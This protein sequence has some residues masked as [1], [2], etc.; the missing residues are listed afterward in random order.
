VI[1]QFA[2]VAS[3]LDPLADPWREPFMRLALAEVVLLGAIGGAL[4]CWI[5]LY[6]LAY[7]AESLAHGM[8]PGLAIA[9]LTAIPLALGGL[10]GGLVAAL[11]IA[12]VARAP[13]TERDTAVAIAVTALFGLGTLIALSPATPAGLGEVLFG[14]VLSLTAGD[15]AATAALV[16]AVLIGLRLAHGQLLVVGFDRTGARALGG[17]PLAAELI[18]LVLVALAVAVGVEALGNLLV[19][20]LLVAPAAAARHVTDRIVPAMAVG[21]VIAIAAGVIGLYVSW[22]AGTAGGAS[23]ALAA[24][25]LYLLVASAARVRAGA[26]RIS[27]SA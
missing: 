21:A 8:L 25:A 3:I 2:T 23:I 7:S 6:G 22:H 24:L 19:L 20:A 10:V 12:I 9:A 5:V 15:V 13:R 17:R 16:V 27:R 1:A 14:D 18:L 26:A 11:T 4:G